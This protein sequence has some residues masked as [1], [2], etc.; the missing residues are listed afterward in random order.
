MKNEFELYAEAGVGN[1]C[2][3]YGSLKIIRKY[4]K[5]SSREQEV[6]HYR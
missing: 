5:R 3:M 2:L 1:V 4:I 6:H